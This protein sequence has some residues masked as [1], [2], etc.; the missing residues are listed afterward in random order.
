MFY[1]LITNDCCKAHWMKTLVSRS[2]SRKKGSLC[3]RDCIWSRD[4]RSDH[5]MMNVDHVVL[6]WIL[7]LDLGNV[8]LSPHYFIE[9]RAKHQCCW[10]LNI[11]LDIHSLWYILDMYCLFLRSYLDWYRNYW[12]KSLTTVLVIFSII[13]CIL[14][15]YSM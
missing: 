1:L 7:G 4:P 14:D 2:N 8:L 5:V 3:Y 6:W 10:L 11:F 9:P 15:I 12:I 13:L